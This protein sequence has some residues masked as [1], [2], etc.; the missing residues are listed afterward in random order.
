MSYTVDSRCRDCNKEDR[1]VDLA[2]LMGAVSGIHGVNGW[3]T[4]ANQCITK[5]HLGGGSITLNCVNFEA[6]PAKEPL[7]M[8]ADTEAKAE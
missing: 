2:I 3:S 6:Q 8:P 7:P 4:K 1:C 5:G